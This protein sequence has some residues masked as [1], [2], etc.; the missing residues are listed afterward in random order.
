MATTLE[1]AKAHL[2]FQHPFFASILMRRALVETH[3]LTPTLGVDQYGTI[4]YNP[5]FTD[6]LT[7]DEC[8][9]GLAHEVMHVVWQHAARLFERDHR[10][11]NIATDAAI[12]DMLIDDNVGTF[13]E[14]GVRMPGSAAKTADTIYNELA[15]QCP[16]HGPTGRGGKGKGSGGHT[17]DTTGLPCTCDGDDED[18][19]GGT[20][21]DLVRVPGP[22]LTADQI[23]QQAAEMRVA[24]AQALQTAKMQGKVP[25]KI[26]AWAAQLIESK[27]PWFEILERFMTGFAKTTT[28]WARRNRRYTDAYLPWVTRTPA[29]GAVVLQV[30]VSGSISQPELD[31]YA[32]H[33][34]RIL[35]QCRPTKV[36]VLY[37][38]TEVQKHVEFDPLNG[39]E[40]KL[41]FYSGGGT[42][43][44][45]GFRWVDTHLADVD[46]IVCLTDGYTPFTANPT[47]LPIVWCV[48][49][50]IV[51]T[52]GEHVPFSLDLTKS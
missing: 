20:G 37:V 7:V 2:V 16:K 41:E 5:A 24:V 32:G 29:M 33:M 36:H 21:Q 38:D 34:V 51:P 48:S 26:G 11:W 44:E 46:V 6:K 17:H 1:R 9:F 22:P 35:E 40:V 28:S 50:D 13:I 19:M 14:G 43:M 8:I 15:Q 45:A 25:G 47:T 31:H 10:R 52:Y 12:N 42:D 27:V 4:Y 3:T 39:D 23:K 49:T 30:D 18:G